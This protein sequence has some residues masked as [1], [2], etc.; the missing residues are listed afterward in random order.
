MVI[1]TK[2]CV[3]FCS[4]LLLSDSLSVDYGCSAVSLC[5]TQ[6]VMAEKQCYYEPVE[7]ITVVTWST[8]QPSSL[9]TSKPVAS[10]LQIIGP[11]GTSDLTTHLSLAQKK[12]AG[13]G[14]IIKFRITLQIIGPLSTS[15]LKTHLSLVQKELALTSDR[16]LSSCSLMVIHSA[17]LTKSNSSCFCYWSHHLPPPPAHNKNWFDH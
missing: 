16:S 12:F 17:A 11:A 8:R 9:L 5:S 6:A 7:F 2:I 15:D 10:T 14:G 13:V 1:M 3:V 4:T